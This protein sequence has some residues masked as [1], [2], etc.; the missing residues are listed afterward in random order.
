M[1]RRTLL[2]GAAAFAAY[3][4]LSACGGGSDGGG[5]GTPAAGGAPAAS[6]SAEP[7]VSGTGL[8]RIGIQLY[9]VRDK[10]AEDV[11]G[12]LQ[13]IAEIGY[14]EVEF[15]GYFDY[16]PAEIMSMLNANG[17]TSP[18]SHVS[19]AD[20]RSKPEQLIE[21]AHGI[22]NSYVALA[23]LAP[24]DRQTLDA[25]RSH[26]ELV[27]GFAERCKSAGLQFAWHNHDFE[28]IELEGQVPMDM[29]LAQTDADLV[30][31]ELDLYWTAKAQ[32]NPFA[33]FERHPGRFPMCHVKDM[34]ADTSIADVGDGTIDFPALFAAS[35]QAGFQHYFVE[36]D[37]PVDSLESATRSYAAAAAMRF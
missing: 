4:M 28:F 22:G 23:W 3:P 11:P 2:K 17:L 33:Y 12:T 21:I 30:Q 9:T 8:E 24:E 5:G 18:S 6:G 14:D 37:D 1:K 16:T 7:A 31:V 36:R 19:L 29:I 10:M 15:A 35:E 20:I 34:A 27:A 26:I 32:V 25:Y 13:R